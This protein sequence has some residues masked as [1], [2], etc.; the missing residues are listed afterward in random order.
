MARDNSAMKAFY[1]TNWFHAAHTGGGMGEIWHHGAVALMREKRPIPYRS[2]HDTRQWVMELSRRHDGSIGIAGMDDRYHRTLTD[3]TAGRAWGTYFALTYTYPR[4]ALQI[5]GAPR[6]QW[7]KHFQL[8]QRP[9]GNAADDIFNSPDPVYIGEGLKLTQEALLNETV[10]KDASLAVLYEHEN[11]SLTEKDLFKRLLHPEYAYRAGAMSNVVGKG[12]VHLV[13]PLLKSGDPRLRHAGLL[14]LTGMFKGPSLKQDQI[15]PEMFEL[16]GAMIED[17]D[18]S[19]WV[20]LYAIKALNRA[21]ADL[22]AQH[23]DRLIE[24]LRYDSDWLQEASI[25]TLTKIANDQKHYKAVYPAIIYTTANLTVDSSSYNATQAIRG[26]IEGA[27]SEVKAFASPLLKK[28]YADFP[29]ELKDPYTGAV[30]KNGAMTVR[31][32]IGSVIEKLPD[33]EEFVRRIPKTTLK[34][35]ISGKESDM[36]TYDGKF[37]PNDKL[38]GTWHWAVHPNPKT[39]SDID[40]TIESW[41]KPKGNG[42]INLG[43][44]KDVLVIENGGKT[45][46][47]RYYPKYF[48]TG[49][50]L[51]GNEDGVAL[52]MQVRTYNGIDFLIIEKGKFGDGLES[53]QLDEVPRDYHCGFFAYMRA[54]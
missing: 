3:A 13:V 11:P 2:Y 37:T 39:P 52:K 36:F 29:H 8:P 23:R 51:I 30:M 10:L 26:A 25:R 43:I 44:P 53:E 27:S 34:S 48:W 15:T 16:A 14:A 22:V 32:R 50:T 17:P 49:D 41:L 33:G 19:W 45:S 35:F 4:K 9:W 46:K 47:S 38:T 12:W 28:V 20:T 40:S 5:W 18:E 7:A 6:S 21:D 42:P 1:A 54:E 24:L 31:K